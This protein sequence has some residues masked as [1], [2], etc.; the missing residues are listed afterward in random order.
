MVHVDKN[1]KVD[2]LANLGSTFK[3]HPNIKIWISYLIKPAIEDTKE[4]VAPV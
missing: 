3:T 1:T 4:V 2:A